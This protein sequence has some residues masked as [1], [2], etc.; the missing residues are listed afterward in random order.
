MHKPKT[1]VATAQTLSEM[2]KDDSDVTTKQQNEESVS[3]V[4]NGEVV[5]AMKAERHLVSDVRSANT[6]SYE[7]YKSKIKGRGSGKG[8]GAASSGGKDVEVKGK[9]KG[10][11]KESLPDYES[12]EDD[13]D[14][15]GRNTAPASRSKVGAGGASRAP[16]LERAPW[17]RDTPFPI[18]K[19]RPLGMGEDRGRRKWLEA[20]A[21]CEEHFAQLK[22]RRKR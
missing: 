8:S 1:K 15:K 3:L 10:N 2:L 6:S 13:E 20:L 4:E 18:P 7:I 21:E 12:E 11:S 14:S 5:P 9:G 17:R 19:A 22:Q 16:G